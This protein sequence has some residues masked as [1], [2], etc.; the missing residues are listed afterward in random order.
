[1]QLTVRS[2]DHYKYF[3]LQHDRRDEVLKWKKGHCPFPNEIYD[4]AVG[5]I[6][7]YFSGF[8]VVTVP[9]PSFHTYRNH[10][11]PI[12][13]F[14]KRLRG[15]CR[16]VLKNLFPKPSGKTRKHFTGWR[17][18]DVQDIRLKPGLFVLVVDDIATTGHTMRITYEAILR[19]GSYPCGIAL[20]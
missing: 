16:L 3:L 19:K 1:M 14:A 4:L 17:Q 2:R 11:Y 12:W 9:A 15:D 20:A 10:G 13:E 7:R 5:V 6:Q 8:D 18:K